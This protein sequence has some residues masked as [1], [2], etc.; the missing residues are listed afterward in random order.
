M[1]ST[2]IGIEAGT[3]L[4]QPRTLCSAAAAADGGGS[5]T[6]LV[7]TTRLAFLCVFCCL[8]WVFVTTVVAPYMAPGS[9]KAQ[10]VSSSP[11]GGRAGPR[12]GDGGANSSSTITAGA[13]ASGGDADDPDARASRRPPR[14]L[15]VLT[16]YG[17]RSAF[18][19]PYKDAVAARGDGFQPTVS[20]FLLLLSA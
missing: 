16:T 10:H 18:V 3:G 19:K 13:E 11:P 1:N 12:P 6:R 4:R 15:T 17:K 8:Q 2:A 9:E 5:A 7:T 14:I 20:V